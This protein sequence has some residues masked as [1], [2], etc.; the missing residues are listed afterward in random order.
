MDSDRRHGDLERGPW[1]ELAK[2]T[3]EAVGRRR[4]VQRGQDLVR[5]PDCASRPGDEPVERHAA[6]FEL[7][8]RPSSQFDFRIEKQ[9]RNDHVTGG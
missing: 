6:G 2:S 5:F 9:Q 8:T 7:G 1:A 4:K 3:D